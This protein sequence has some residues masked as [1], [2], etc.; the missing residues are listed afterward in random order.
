[1]TLLGRDHEKLEISC[2]DFVVEGDNLFFAVADGE[3]NIHIFQYDP[4]SSYLI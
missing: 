2:G 1:M 3:R 4:E